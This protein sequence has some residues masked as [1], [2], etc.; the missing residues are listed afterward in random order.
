MVNNFCF[1]GVVLGGREDPDLRFGQAGL[2]NFYFYL[3]P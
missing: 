1:N 3:A 2:G